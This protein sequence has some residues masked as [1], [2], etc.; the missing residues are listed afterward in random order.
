MYSGQIKAFFL[1]YLQPTLHT[2]A[3]SS[4]YC[5]VFINVRNT[6]SYT[7]IL[8]VHLQNCS[9][10]TI[11]FRP[12]FLNICLLTSFHFTLKFCSLRPQLLSISFP[13]FRSF[14]LTPSHLHPFALVVLFFSSLRNCPTPP[15]CNPRNAFQFSL[16]ICRTYIEKAFFPFC[17]TIPQPPFPAILLICR[18]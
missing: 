1:P 8:P 10:T 7:S 15:P 16:P 13:N 17:R 3:C 6:L 18:L 11:V 9:V 12:Q 5:C 4:A 2:S 14:T